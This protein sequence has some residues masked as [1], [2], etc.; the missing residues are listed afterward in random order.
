MT[1]DANAG[2]LRLERPLR[3]RRHV[4]GTPLN[5]PRSRCKSPRTF[6]LHVEQQRIRGWWFPL[7]R[8]A[9]AHRRCLSSVDDHSLEVVA[10]K[11]YACAAVL[12]LPDDDHPVA[13]RQ[14]LLAEASVR[15]NIQRPR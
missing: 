1:Y 8:H 5:K 4:Y 6:E 2:H 11:S 9:A 10:Q 7:E 13:G 12:R 14:V 3:P 15:G